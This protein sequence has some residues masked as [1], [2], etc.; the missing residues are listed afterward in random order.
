MQCGAQKPGLLR[1]TLLRKHL[2][3]VTQAMAFTQSEMELLADY[4]GHNIIINQSFYKMTPDVLHLA[5]MSKLLIAM[6]DGTISNYFGKQF[7]DI[8]VADDVVT[9]ENYNVQK[10]GESLGLNKLD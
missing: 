7:D 5:K 10:K 2:A 6:E 3:T 1:G 8:N 4:M 9:M